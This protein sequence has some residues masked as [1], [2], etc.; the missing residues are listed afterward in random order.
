MDFMG[1]DGELIEGIPTCMGKMSI[2][3][4]TKHSIME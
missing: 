4:E 1:I 2:E 3:I